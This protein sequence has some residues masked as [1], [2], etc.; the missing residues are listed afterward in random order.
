MERLEKHFATW[1]EWMEFLKTPFPPDVFKQSSQEGESDFN[2]GASFKDAM[3]FGEF[4]WSDGLKKITPLRDALVTKLANLVPVTYNY[5]H[6]TG[7]FFDVPSVIEGMPEQ[8]IDYDEELSDSFK[9]VTIVVNGSYSC[10]VST[11]VVL[12]RGA[13]IA[14]L[15]DLLEITNVRCNVVLEMGFAERM[16]QDSLAA[17]RINIKNFDQPLDLNRLA[18]ALAHAASFRRLGFKFL[19]LYPEYHR[20][21]SY[22]YGYPGEVPKDRRGNIYIEQMQYDDKNTWQDVTFAKAWVIEQLKRQGIEIM[23][24]GA[25]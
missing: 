24:A 14:A 21:C 13:C 3:R 5:Y 16:R 8:W 23:T 6:V 7:R 15:V 11:D 9:A 4:G 17:V 12:A 20:T 22:G 1:G 25:Q 19:E 10:G 18:F 2:M